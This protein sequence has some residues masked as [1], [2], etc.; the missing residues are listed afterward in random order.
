MTQAGCGTGLHFGGFHCTITTNRKNYRKPYVVSTF[1]SSRGSCGGVLGVSWAALGDSGGHLAASGVVF[2]PRWPVSGVYSVTFG[3]QMGYVGL[4]C[5]FSLPS[6]WNLR[7]VE[8]LDVSD[9][10]PP[11]WDRVGGWV[12]G[13]GIISHDLVT[14]KRSADF[15]PTTRD[16]HGGRASLVYGWIGVRLHSCFLWPRSSGMSRDPPSSFPL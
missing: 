16:G 12:R 8:R 2:G 5:F 14:L 9:T 11:N 10:F 1:W 13:K 15:F 3:G 7:I 4:S 6:A